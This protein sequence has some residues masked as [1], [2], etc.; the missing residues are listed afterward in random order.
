MNPLT[1]LAILAGAGLGT[2]CALLAAGMRKTIDDP[3]RPGSR[4]ARLTARARWFAGLSGSS[5]ER[6]ARRAHLLLALIAAVGAY[7]LSGVVMLGVLTGYAVLGAPLLL[8]PGTGP[9]RQI[10]RSAALGQWTRSLAVRIATGSGLEQ[11]L[12]AAAVEAPEPVADHVKQVAARL[13]AGWAT[14]EALKAFIQET[15][16]PAADFTGTALR[17]AAVRRGAGLSLVLDRLAAGVDAR[18]RTRQQIE[19]ERAR[20]RTTVRLINL[21]MIAMFVGLQFDNAFMAPYRTVFGQLLLTVFAAAYT[22]C[23]IAMDRLAKG[24]EEPRLVG[25]DAEAA[26]R[27]RAI[28]R[29]GS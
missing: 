28:G 27:L 14:P 20:M 24:D 10:A 2:G 25:P 3:S 5:S 29:D 8:Q 16:E 9:A 23:L 15:A 13:Q 19:A 18:V 22:G 17:R 12:V 6:R 26:P 1:A 7:L 11:A 4:T 21:I